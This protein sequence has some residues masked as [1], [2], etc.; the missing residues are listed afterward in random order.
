MLIDQNI[1]NIGTEGNPIPALI[2]SAWNTGERPG[3]GQTLE[4]EIRR[5][6][7]F[8]V[9]RDV[10]EYFPSLTPGAQFVVLP[11]A[12]V[13]AVDST[14]DTRGTFRF[15]RAPADAEDEIAMA[16]DASS[17][18]TQLISRPELFDD[19][20]N[21]P[22]VDGVEDGFRVTVVLATLYAVLAALAGIALTARERARDLG[23]LR[24]LGLTSRQATILTVIEQLPPA[25][26]ATA[27]GAV[28]GIALVWL[29]EPGLD[30]STF[31][32][33]T[34]P[35]EVL[36]DPGVL[37]LVTGAELLTILIAIAIYS[38]LTRRMNLGNVLR[39]GDR[40]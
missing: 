35:A 32:G 18:S 19:L 8:I 26:L 25:V 16:L 15:L 17:P 29:V 9:V 12:S 2:S 27:A 21:A 38:Y 3:I 13:E 22:L 37:V 28:L 33:A 10:R 4:I 14:V 40:T 39:L 6:S 34:L 36:A 24:T 30:L 1:Q 11:R 5:Q 23:Y 31:A 20:A 7:F